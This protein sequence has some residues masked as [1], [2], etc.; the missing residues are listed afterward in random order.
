MAKCDTFT[1]IPLTEK[2]QTVPDEPSKP[3]TLRDRCD[4]LW[5]WIRYWWTW[6]GAMCC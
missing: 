2:T 5:Y 1:D 3:Q 4:T 6:I